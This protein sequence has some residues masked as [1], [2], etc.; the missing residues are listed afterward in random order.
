MFTIL[1]L[2][3]L[4]HTQYVDMFTVCLC[5]KFHLLCSDDSLVVSMKPI[6]N[7]KFARFY[8]FILVSKKNVIL[9]NVSYF[10]VI[11]YQLMSSK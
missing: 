11:L 5:I 4:F 7:E 3:I 2:E 6:L 8:I 10:S 1:E 9:A